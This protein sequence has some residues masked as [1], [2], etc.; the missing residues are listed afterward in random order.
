MCQARHKEPAAVVDR[1]VCTR[2]SSNKTLIKRNRDHIALTVG[3]SF[4]EVSRHASYNLLQS[5]SDKCWAGFA[6]FTK[7]KAHAK[8]AIIEK[9]TAFSR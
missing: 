7:T 5:S 6:D 8:L 2:S 4:I 9:L 1:Q 3:A